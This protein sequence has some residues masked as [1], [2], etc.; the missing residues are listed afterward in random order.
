MLRSDTGQKTSRT[1]GEYQTKDVDTKPARPKEAAAPV[2]EEPKEI[3]EPEVD[4]KKGVTFAA[5]IVDDLGLSHKAARG[6]MAL[7]LDLTLA[8]LPYEHNSDKIAKE[9]RGKGFELMLHMPMEPYNYL[10]GKNP[11]EGALL[12]S[13]TSDEIIKGANDMI[14]AVGAVSGINNH[15]GSKFCEDSEKMSDVMGVIKERSLYFVD[16]LTTDNSCGIKTAESYGVEN[17]SRNIFLDNDKEEEKILAQLDK[18]IRISKKRGYAIAICHPYK[19][20]LKALEKGRERLKENGIEI[21]RVSE[22]IR[23]RS[24]KLNEKARAKTV[25]SMKIK[26]SLKPVNPKKRRLILPQATP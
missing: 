11:G 26:S 20:T 16:S 12:M 15:M 23:I 22:I 14:T 1:A 5:I 10:D 8:I 3:I 6:F 13:M 18:V 7:G 9:A 4:D 17:I 25:S 21:V 24:K 19:E 2:K